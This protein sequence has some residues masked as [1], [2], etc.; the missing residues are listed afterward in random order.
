[1]HLKFRNLEVFDLFARTENVSETARTLG[2][3]QPAVSQVLRELEAQIGLSLFPRSG[4]TLSLTPE[5]RL[6]LPHIGR[7][8]SQMM[9]VGQQVQ[10]IRDGNV[11]SLSVACVPPLALSMLPMAIAELRRQRPGVLLRVGSHTAAEVSHEVRQERADIG[12]ALLPI[13]TTGL[14]IEKIVET[15]FVCLAHKDS[16]LAARNF[17]TIEDLRDRCVIAQGANT[18]PGFL[19]H[20]YFQEANAEFA[21]TIEVNRSALS[22]R[23]VELGVGVAFSHPFV[24][25]NHTSSDVRAIP[26]RP[27]LQIVVAF[28]FL[29]ERISSPHISTFV[30]IVRDQMKQLSTNLNTLGLSCRVS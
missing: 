28:V 16:D 9:A 4:R 27:S 14:H 11:G 10:S 7:L 1:M 17:I 3:S 19:L 22:Y 12:V 26:F 2:V 20:R 5:A 21:N 29:K 23:L 13:N 8:R 25:P 15:E 6:L 18:V 30:E 24:I